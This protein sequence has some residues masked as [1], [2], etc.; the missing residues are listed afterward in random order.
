MIGCVMKGVVRLSEKAT[1]TDRQT[2]RHKQTDKQTNNQTT[3]RQTGTLSISTAV[4]NSKLICPYSRSPDPPL[5]DPPLLREVRLPI[6][7][8]LSP[9][10][11]LLSWAEGDRGT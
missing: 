1:E 11:E 10:N 2:D 9:D 7:S 5:L 3:D 8:S 4:I 6:S